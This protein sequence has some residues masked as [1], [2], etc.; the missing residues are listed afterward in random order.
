MIENHEKRKPSIQRDIKTE[1][2]ANQSVASNGLS[3][4]DFSISQSQSISN[5]PE[6]NGASTFQDPLLEEFS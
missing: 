1:M 5:T 6:L 4:L 3:D 2:I